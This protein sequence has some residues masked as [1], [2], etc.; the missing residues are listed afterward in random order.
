MKLDKPAGGTLYWKQILTWYLGLHFLRL[1]CSGLFDRF[2]KL[3]LVIG[4]MG[5][6]LPFQYE[7]LLSVTARIPDKKARDLK[8]VWDENLWITT[9]GMFSLV[10]LECLLKMKGKE[11]V[12]FSIDY[13]FS[14]NE[15]GRKFVD[16]IEKSGLLTG[17]ELK[18]FAYGNAERLLRVNI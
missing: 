4:H 17:E 1:Y 3:K 6:L 5:E 9:S 8:T 16:E 2:P 12:L 13:P 18:A 7:R 10:A 14:S 15:T 11:K